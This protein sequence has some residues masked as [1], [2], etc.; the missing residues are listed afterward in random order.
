MEQK[1]TMILSVLSKF[2]FEVQYNKFL[3]LANSLRDEIKNGA[4][5]VAWGD[6]RNLKKPFDESLDPGHLSVALERLVNDI[7]EKGV[8]LGLDHVRVKHFLIQR[9]VETVLDST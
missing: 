4:C 8:V 6:E 5:Q 9:C 2:T 7:E 3:S 1:F